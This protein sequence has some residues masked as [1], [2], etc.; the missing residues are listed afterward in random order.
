[1]HFILFGAVV[2]WLNI[3]WSGRIIR[4][5][6][7]AIP[8]AIVVPLMLAA[9]EEGLQAFSSMRTASLGDLSCD[10]A[11]MVVFWWMSQKIINVKLTYR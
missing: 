11:G 2:F 8:L 7:W 1:M 10:V 9:T 4:W 3:W 6:W 5:G